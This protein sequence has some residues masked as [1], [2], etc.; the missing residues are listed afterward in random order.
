MRQL[1]Q[2]DSAVR[3]ILSECFQ[4]MH[5]ARATELARSRRYLEAT[6]LLM[7]QGRLPADAK[8]L[9]LLA[10]IAAQ[11]RRFADAERLWKCAS[12]AGPENTAYRDA[13]IRAGR[14]RQN[15]IQIKQAVFAVAV[16]L[17]LASIVL[18]TINFFSG[19]KSKPASAIKAPATPVSAV[20]IKS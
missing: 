18:I 7:P 16:A 13:A 20:P 3:A 4:E 5:L 15:W 1:D 14:T 11:Q 6:A 17:V 2:P 8:E 9:D 12:S 10:R 19:G